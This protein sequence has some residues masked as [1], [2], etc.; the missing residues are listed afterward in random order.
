MVATMQTNTRQHNAVIFPQIIIGYV[1]FRQAFAVSFVV[2]NIRVTATSVLPL[3][4]KPSALMTESGCNLLLRL[5]GHNM[6][7]LLQTE[8]A[9]D[10]RLFAHRG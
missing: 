7:K 3:L 5:R 4:P 9:I 6:F 1:N 2:V 8:I 10:V